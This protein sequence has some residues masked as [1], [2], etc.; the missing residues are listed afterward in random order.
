MSPYIDLTVETASRALREAGISLT[1]DA[2][3][4][5]AEATGCRLRSVPTPNA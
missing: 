2:L 5:D 4:I 1:A 3:A